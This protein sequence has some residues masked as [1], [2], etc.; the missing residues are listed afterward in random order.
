MRSESILSTMT[1]AFSGP[2]AAFEWKLLHRF[3]ESLAQT[4]APVSLD[5]LAQSLACERS[6]IVQV[7]DE[8]YP[9]AEYDPSGNLVGVGLTLR[10]TTHQIVFEN[11]P[12][13]TWCAP[14]A[15]TIPVVLG[16]PAQIISQC[17]VT[18]TRI[19]V[20]LTPEHLEAYTPPGAVVSFAK[21]GGMVKRLKEAGCIRQGG[22]ANQFFF[23]SQ[24]VAAPW[25]SQHADF[26]V[27]PLEE[28]FE[29][30]RKFTQ[31]QMALAS[32]A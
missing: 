28:A 31:Q 11:Q 20:A 4:G 7:L 17:P 22:C 18:G 29:D 23:A 24:E 25:V 6:Q 5:T 9:E 8:Q 21:H 2:D 3:W 14:D 13:Y 32:R 10:P 26:S 30:L 19:E 27:F 12:F 1:T 15:F 16:R